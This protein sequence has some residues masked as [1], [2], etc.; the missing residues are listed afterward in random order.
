VNRAPVRNYCVDLF[1]LSGKHAVVVGAGGIGAV[2]ALALA[3][4]GADVAIADKELRRAEDT[5]IAVR[6]LGGEALALAVDVTSEGKVGEMAASIYAIF[7]RVDILVNCFGAVTR[8]PSAVLSVAEW[9][10]VMD[11]NALGTFLCCQAFG[12][13]MIKH[14]GGK[15]VN[16]SS[17]RGRYGTYKGNADYCASKA[18]VDG[19]T[20]QLAV[21]WARHGV[22][23][24]A[25]A[26]TVVETDLTSEVIGDPHAAQVLRESIPQGRWAKADDLVGPVLFFVSAASDYVTGQV[27]YV[28]GGLTALI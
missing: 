7:P 9:Q 14:G 8:K 5:A 28:D 13:E 3:G 10:Q 12:R 17:V 4:C 18:A 24:N 20:R 22:R 19:L 16:M 15:I 6:A 1:D 25:I 23:V 21:E 26:P 11:V 27:L 2:L